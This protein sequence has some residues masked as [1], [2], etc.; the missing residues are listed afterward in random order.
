MALVVVVLAL[1]S[2][3]VLLTVDGA[4]PLADG[5]APARCDVVATTP[6]ELDRALRD[7]GPGTHACVRGGGFAGTDVRIARS[8]SELRP[9]VVVADDAPVRSVAVT[10][11]HV[12]VEGF[13]TVPGGGGIDLE[14]RG[15]V[16]RDN[17]LDGPAEDGVACNTCTDSVVENNVVSGADGSGV[18]VEGNRIIV[19]GN[20]VSGSVR[21]EAS[22]ADGIRFFGTGIVV[23]GNRVSDITHAGYGDGA[24]HTDCFQTFDNSRPPTVGAR[25]TRNTCH[26]VDDQCLIATAEESGL[27][28]AVGRSRGIE[29]TDNQCDVGGAQAVLIRWIPDTVVEGNRL[30]GSALDRGAYFGDGSVR[31]SF[32]GNTTPP[33]V[34]P[35]QIDDGS[36]VGF[37][38]DVVQ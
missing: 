36:L 35:V 7:A 3:L 2:A 31:G 24:P 13:A 33:G 18:L 10:A 12:V 16:A 28:G 9:L 37:R 22:D 14:G 38:T 26:N 20:T 29:F 30:G 11:D 21:R 6:V 1:S 25:V 34:R 15:L 17:R 19:R 32:V 4:D 8:G 23:D 5:A 27:Q